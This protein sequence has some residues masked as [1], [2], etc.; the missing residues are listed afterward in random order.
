MDYTTANE[1]K[2]SSDDVYNALT[3]HGYLQA[4]DVLGYRIGDHARTEISLDLTH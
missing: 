2:A 1:A 3:P 4:M